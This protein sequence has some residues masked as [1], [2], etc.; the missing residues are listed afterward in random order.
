[1]A[2]IG[3]WICLP[4]AKPFFITRLHPYQG[5]L[6]NSQRVSLTCRV[7]C[8]P[9]C[10]LAWLKDGQPLHNTSH[11][12]VVS[13]VLSPDPS[14]GDLASVQSVL[15]WRM[16]NWPSKELDREM[17]NG[18]YECVSSS[19]AAGPSVSSNTFFRV[20]FSVSVL[21]SL[22]LSQTVR[23]RTLY[24]SQ[25]VRQRT[26]YLSQTVRHRTLYLSPTVRQRTLYLSQTVR[27]RTL[28]L[29]QTVRQRTLYLSQTVRQLTLYLTNS[30]SAYPLPDK[31]YVSVPSTCH[32]Q[33][34]SVPSTCHQRYISVS[35]TCHKQ[36]VSVPSDC[37]KR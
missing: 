24:L 12:R 4:T 27:Q 37:Y 8:F 11:Y 34:V 20:E 29:S 26:P 9:L 25:T 31:Q 22:Y 15:H 23:Q 10:S 28:Y 21:P 13:S 30:T 33:F 36:Y 16:D 17:D 14:S 18:E 5:F 19:N 32:K 2:L 7:E 6:M 3:A 35:F 1:M